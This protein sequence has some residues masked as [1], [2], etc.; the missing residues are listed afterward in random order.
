MANFF[1]LVKM[2]EDREVRQAKQLEITRAQLEEAKAASTPAKQS[3]FVAG[4]PA[5]R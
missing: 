1:T 3:D 4:T 5:K 2:L